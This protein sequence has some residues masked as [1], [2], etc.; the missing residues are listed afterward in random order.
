MGLTSM[1]LSVTS[2]TTCSGLK[3]R[4]LSGFLSGLDLARSSSLHSAVVSCSHSAVFSP[5]ACR[6]AGHVCVREDLQEIVV[7][8]A[9]R[10]QKLID[11]GQR[12]RVL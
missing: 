11:Q 3:T 2:Q 8:S 6:N 7:D 1:Y 9:V 10:L 5:T 12:A 4:G